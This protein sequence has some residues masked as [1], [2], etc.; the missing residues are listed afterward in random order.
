MRL[1][2]ALVMV[3][4]KLIP[5]GGAAGYTYLISGSGSPAINATGA[6]TGLCAGAI[7]TITVSDANLAT[8]TT[9]I[10]ISEPT[11]LTVSI[12]SSNDPSCVPG[13]DGTATVTSTGG[14]GSN[15]FTIAP[16]GTIDP[17][18]GAAS[19]LC[20]GITYTITVTDVNG[21]VSTTSIL[22][23]TPGSPVI[24][25]TSSTDP[26]CVPGCD[27][28]ATV[29]AIVGGN[30][31]IAPSGTIDPLTGAA[32][33]LCAGITYTITVTDGNGCTG[34][35]TV[36]LT[37]PGSPIINITSSTNPSCL[38]GCDGTATVTAIV[39]GTYSIAP[40]GTI[41]PVT[42]AASA[43]CSGITYTITVTD[44]NSCTGTT[45]ILLTTPGS[46]V[47]AITSSTDPSCVPGCDGTATV[48]AIAGGYI[49]NSPKWNNRSSNGSGQC[50]VC[51]Y[52]IHHYRN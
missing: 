25:I 32:T 52:H 50:L 42:G 18:T 48:T 4:P 16:S 29:T 26:S 20:A 24:N 41:D 35:T 8:A 3:L 22:L 46:P 44:A 17:L 1:A 5:S 7:Y 36:Q 39:G 9:T 51:R 40:S 2:L 49:F 19:A 27:G 13:C 11:Q 37:T 28:T 43:L 15:T 12:T 34:T 10:V 30:Y 14:S 6:A 47:I 31:T 23:N 38:P 45:S 21:C 33:A